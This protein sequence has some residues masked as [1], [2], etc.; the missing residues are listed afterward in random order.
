[1]S[2]DNKI[3]KIDSLFNAKTQIRYDKLAEECA[4]YL[5]AYFKKNDKN[6]ISEIAD[7]H[8]ISRGLVSEKADILK[9]AN[10]KADRTLKRLSEGYYK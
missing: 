2:L 4:E 10:K 8:N 7:I 5:E 9:A 1:M 3:K 6:I